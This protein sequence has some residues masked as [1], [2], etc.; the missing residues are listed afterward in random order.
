M[1]LYEENDVPAIMYHYSDVKQER[2]HLGT[3]WLDGGILLSREFLIK[4]KWTIPAID[5]KR[6]EKHPDVS[7]GVWTYVSRQ[8]NNFKQKILKPEQSLAYHDGN[9]DSKMNWMCREKRKINSV[10]FK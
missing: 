3:N 5:P 8:I 6:F 1:K 2:W 10:N 4:I 9:C 7:S